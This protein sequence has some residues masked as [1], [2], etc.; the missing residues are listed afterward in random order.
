MY[1]KDLV[2]K[3]LE[4]SN[5][6]KEVLIKLGKEVNGGSYRSLKRFITEN[7]LILPF[8][9]MSREEYEKNPKHCLSCG[10]EID[11]EHRYNKYCS[12]SCSAHV[13]NTKFPKR[14]KENGRTRNY[15]ETR[16]YKENNLYCIVCGKKLTGNQKK[17]CSV[18]CKNKCYSEEKY[19]TQYSNNKDKNGAVKKYEYILK[20]GGRCSKCGYDKNLSA[21]TF[22]HL[23]DKDFT[24]TSR[25]F[26]RLPKEVIEKE[27]DK[28][29]LLCQNCHHETHYPELD[30]EI[31]KN[32]LKNNK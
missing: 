30:K 7:G 3:L 26:S 10:K 11:Y 4:E 18:N 19:H 12:K 25:A 6:L 2:S 8:K 16:K 29:V 22:H 23:R 5:S 21:L 24:L 20:L 31:L 32:I 9:K 13:N 17:F 14:T 27:L 15:P 28:C 1:D